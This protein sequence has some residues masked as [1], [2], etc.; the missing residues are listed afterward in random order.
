MDWRGGGVLSASFCGWVVAGQGFFSVVMF[1]FC[2]WVAADWIFCVVGPFR[3]TTGWHGFQVEL[4]LYWDRNG[5]CLSPFCIWVIT[6][7]CW[8]A[9]H[10]IMVSF[11][12]WVTISWGAFRLVVAMGG[13]WVATGCVAYKVGFP[14]WYSWVAVGLGTIFEG[15]W[16]QVGAN[17]GFN[18]ISL[19][20]GPA[21]HEQ[22]PFPG[23][24]FLVTILHVAVIGGL[25]D[26]GVMSLSSCMEARAI[27]V[28]FSRFEVY[29]V[30][31]SSWFVSSS[32]QP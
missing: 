8:V 23:V 2:G 17:A 21:Q 18:H 19:G 24:C 31:C 16:G 10:F 32:L 5:V 13:S 15:V 22:L 1:S 30:I 29:C 14:L 11:C 7:I 6:G 3:V 25:T 4:A 28:R 26:K 12:S 27:D 9:F 20:V